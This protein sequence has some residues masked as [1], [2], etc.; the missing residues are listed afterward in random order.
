M[1]N[2]NKEDCCPEFDPNGW[3]EKE[4]IWKNKLFVKDNVLS[5]FYIPINISKVLK[6]MMEKIKKANAEVPENDF[7]ILSHDVNMFKSEQYI[8]VTKKVEGLENVSLSGQYITKVFEGPY[9]EAKN[10][11]KVMKDFVNS[12]DKSLEKLYFHYTTC[13]KCAKKHRKNYVVAFAKVS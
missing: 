3:D 9:R 2:K 5:I 1:S 6:K 4:L 7:F 12:K 13:P 11:V 8:P 10:W